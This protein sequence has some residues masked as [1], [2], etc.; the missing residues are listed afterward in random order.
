MVSDVLGAEAGAWFHVGS[1][2]DD[3][4]YTRC[5]SHFQ[6]V[7]VKKA[8]LWERLRPGGMG[9]NGI[10]MI[11]A[12]CCPRLSQVSCVYSS[13]PLS[14]IWCHFLLF[15]LSFSKLHMEGPCLKSLSSGRKR[16]VS[17][18]HQQQHKKQVPVL[19]MSSS[20]GRMLK[21]IAEIVLP[22]LVAYF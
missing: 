20:K 19:R 15:D 5:L 8:S 18:Q 7:T 11:A 6:S 12:H 10:M 13:H 17:L 3:R 1:R 16:V 2:K 14:S 21:W 4:V 22:N 9:L